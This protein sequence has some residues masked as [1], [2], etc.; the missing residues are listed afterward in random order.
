MSV[1]AVLVLVGGGCAG[2]QDYSSSSTE[3]AAKETSAAMDSMEQVDTDIVIT[4][5]E[6]QGD[7]TLLVEFK[8][9]KKAANTAE[10]YR[11]I[12]SS[13]KTPTWPTK[14]YW[15]QL[16]PSHTEKE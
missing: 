10:G 5:A 14:G 6:P 4:K 7:R 2:A 11:L 15:Y 8:T 1:A 9:S 16:G 12:L 3:Q 13:D